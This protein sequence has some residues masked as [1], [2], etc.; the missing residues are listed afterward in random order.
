[1]Q[2][3]KQSI[4]TEGTEETVPSDSAE[5]RYSQLE[6]DREPYLARA[7][8]ASAL[9]I[10]ALLP[11]AGS[12]GY[13]DLPQPW[14]SLGAKGVNN[15]ASKLAIL[16]YPPEG[17][18]FRL[19]VDD[20]TLA[21]LL[22]NAEAAG[23]EVQ[24]VRGEIEEAFGKVERAVMQRL[25][26]RGARMQ[27]FEACKHLVVTG[28]ILVQVQKNESLKLHRLDRYVVKRDQSGTVVEI[29]VKETV[30]KTTLPD[31]VKAIIS[32]AGARQKSNPSGKDDVDIYTWI[33]LEGKKWVVMQEVYG[34]PIPSAAGT[35]PLDKSP[36]IPV[37]LISVDGEDYGRGFVEEIVGD[38]SAYDGLMQ[39]LIEGAAISSRMIPIVNE[40]GVTAIKD[41]VEAR[42]GEPVQGNINDVKFLQVEKFADLSVAEKAAESLRRELQQSFLLLAGV[43]RNAERVT[44]EEIRLI[45]QE[46]E[47]PFG[48]AYPSLAQDWQKPMT[49]RVMFQMQ[50]RKE[51]PALPEKNIKLQIVTGI[52]GLGRYSELNRL[53]ALIAG[54]NQVFPPEEVSAYVSV[55]GYLRRRATALSL[56]VSGVVRT[57]EQVAEQKQAAMQQEMSKAAIGPVAKL[58]GQQ[59]EAAPPQQ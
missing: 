32:E 33:R 51:L 5:S 38:L 29:V 12:N 34:R 2:R 46:L 17:S 39:A 8:R 24:D 9:T 47:I 49:A 4:N 6:T 41:I 11:P 37:R 54:A 45:A 40:G 21:K 52:A 35:Y 27:K 14:S 58:A 20:F 42:N 44:A 16:L 56:D 31:D 55:G 7:R 3:T 25:D 22:G 57:D 50:K 30:G 48:G 26:E 15:L 13:S 23:E 28:N 18:Y 19:T 53:D 59:M 36:W 10:P 1:M 43:Q